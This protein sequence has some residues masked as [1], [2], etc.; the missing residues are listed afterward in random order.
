[1]DLDRT[2]AMKFD[3]RDQIGNTHK[4]LT[5]EICSQWLTPTLQWITQPKKFFS[6]NDMSNLFK[7]ISPETKKIYYGRK[8]LLYKVR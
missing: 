6:I 7:K 8:K 3:V 2:A 1:M 4:Q 5:L